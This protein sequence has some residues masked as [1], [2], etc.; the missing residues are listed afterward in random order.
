VSRWV[1]C[2]EILTPRMAGGYSFS[3]G[4]SKLWL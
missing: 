1:K 3:A 2:F 4:L